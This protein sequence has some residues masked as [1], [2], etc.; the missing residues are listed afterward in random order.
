MG[1][2]KLKKAVVLVGEFHTKV[3]VACSN[4]GYR[5]S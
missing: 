4:R 2:Y 5:F 3:P 1:F